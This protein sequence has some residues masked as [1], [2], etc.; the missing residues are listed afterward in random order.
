MRSYSTIDEYISGCPP[1]THEQMKTIR[2]TIKELV[3]EADEKIAYGIP[4]FTFHGNLVHF[5]GFKDHVSFFPGGIVY[6]FKDELTG[7]KIAKGTIQFPLDKPL[8]LDL[9]RKIT[10]AAVKRNLERKKQ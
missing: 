3:P 7:Y 8:P 5:G 1:E 2:L 4:T 9:I 6:Q 10:R